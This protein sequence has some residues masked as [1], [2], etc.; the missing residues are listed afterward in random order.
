M[1]KSNLVETPA[2]LAVKGVQVMPRTLII[3][4]MAYKHPTG[5]EIFFSGIFGNDADSK[6]A[7][8]IWIGTFFNRLEAEAY[9]MASKTMGEPV[10]GVRLGIKDEDK[11]GVERIP[12]STPAPVSG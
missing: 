8:D 6:A 11:S 7:G 5:A 9:I 12:D 10:L 3:R 2:Q 1:E 4:P